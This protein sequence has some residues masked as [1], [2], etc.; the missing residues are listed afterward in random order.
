[1]TDSKQYV[2]SFILTAMM[3]ISLFAQ[4]R[5]PYTRQA[6]PTADTYRFI[7]IGDLT[8]GEEPGLFSTAIDRIN[9]L[10]PDF[11]I[12]VGDLIEGYTMDKTIILEQ[13]KQFHQ[14]LDKLEAPFYY[15]P[16]NHDV[17]NP[18]LQ[19]VWDSL[20]NDSY[21]TFHIQNDLFVVLNMFAPGKNGLYP[22][23]IEKIS[24]D[25]KAH[26]PG[27]RIFL[28]SH[29]PLWEGND[30]FLAELAPYNVYYFSGH[31]H[32]YVHRTYKGQEH[33]MLAGLAT[34][35]RNLPEL[36]L[37]HNLMYVTASPKQV[38]LANI[39]LDGLLS[40]SIV[41][42]NSEKQVNLFLSRRWANIR[43]TMISDNSG[44][45]SSVLT[46]N[47]SSDYPLSVNTTPVETQ[48][49]KIHNIDD[50]TVPSGSIQQVE[51]HMELSKGT[52]IDSLPAIGL[53]L[54]GTI[55]Q[56]GKQI[57]AEIFSEWVIDRPRECSNQTDYNIL[58]VHPGE[59]EESWDWT[60]I[61]D[62]TFEYKVYSDRQFVYIDVKTQDDVL[63]KAS[64]NSSVTDKLSI[65]FSPDTVFNTKSYEV[66]DFFPDSADSN[67]IHASLKIPVKKIKNNCFRL[68]IAFTDADNSINLDPAVIWWKPR[69]NSRRD[70]LGAGCFVMNQE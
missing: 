44:I 37:F 30:D 58:C 64:T 48:G 2:L 6:A 9:E 33:Y 36:G 11:V 3:S 38:H 10:A 14:S 15:V 26:P 21:Y 65:Y 41:D 34:G 27:G 40:P 32:H 69:W 35:E 61:E 47:N 39:Q 17:T 55:L 45:I 22:E 59:V 31:E 67:S 60:G 42:E 66:F 19:A 49:V 16:G 53:R 23:Q 12:T 56:P 1:M 63:V 24:R 51:V 70:Y 46:I 54:D 29:A 43:P 28:F 4:E 57:S 62:G 8:G 52:S 7:I 18:V 5:H 68:N 50:F 25:V 20:Y 13:W